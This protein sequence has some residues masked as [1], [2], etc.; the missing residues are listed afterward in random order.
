MRSVQEGGHS[1]L[2]LRK[3]AFRPVDRVAEKEEIQ[4]KRK[5]ISDQLGGI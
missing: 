1:S 5:A 3:N 4:V 2:G